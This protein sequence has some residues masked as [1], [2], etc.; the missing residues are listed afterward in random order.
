MPGAHDDEGPPPRA[1][2]PRYHL[3]PSHG[4]INDPNGMV[5]HDGRWHVFYQ[6]NPEAPVHD[7]IHW[8]H[9]SSP[10]LVAWTEHPVAFGPTAGGP[11]ELGCW[12][13]VFIADA[14]GPA[15]AYSGVR[16]E[17]AQSTICLRRG[18]GDLMEW[19]EPVVV[20]ETPHE[21]GVRIM[22]DPYAFAW[23]GRRWAVLGATLDDGAPA[24]LLWSC[25]DLLAWR[26]ERIWLSGND[27]DL[28]DVAHAEIWECPQLVWCGDAPVLIVSL[29]TGDRPGAAVAITGEVVAADGAPAFRPTAIQPLD[30]T[31][32]FYAPQ[33]VPDPLGGAPLM[34]GW[35]RQEV[36]PAGADVCGCLTLPRR[37][38]V[39]DGRVV[40]T[41]DPAL[42]LLPLGPEQEV[43]PGTHP[44][45]RHT[46]VVVGGHD[47]TLGALSGPLR[48]PAR[49]TVWVDAD[50]VEV[51]PADGSPPTTVR[52]TGWELAV[53]GGGGAS[54]REVGRPRPA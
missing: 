40:V 26:F 25:D 3:R 9:A 50:V 2:L 21:R 18:S 37:L 41:A 8:G 17:S 12:T 51:H 16:D 24:L 38:A 19:G 32:D 27:P 39:E 45:P 28:V 48:A 33:V 11:D 54:V 47:C 36:A 34:I 52:G 20:G 29:C 46:R 15:M 49:A 23:S 43:G 13:G 14:D 30:T 44:L 42:A 22:R 35:A 53:P 10:D 5:H 1:A 6:H 7:R 31:A 4:W